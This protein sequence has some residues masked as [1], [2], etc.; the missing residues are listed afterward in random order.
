M[1]KLGLAGEVQKLAIPDLRFQQTFQNALKREAKKNKKIGTE[2]ND[3]ENISTAVICKVILRDVLFMPFVQGIL[4]TSILIAMKPWLRFTVQQG[5]MC[6]QRLYNFILGKDLV[7]SR[8][9][10]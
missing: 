5:Q 8:R 6:G 7:P 9:G 3:D 10:L 2:G 1:T 4:W